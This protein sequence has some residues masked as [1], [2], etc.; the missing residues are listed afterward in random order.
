MTQQLKVLLDLPEILS[1]GASTYSKQFT[2]DCNSSPRRLYSIFWPPQVAHARAPSHKWCVHTHKFFSFNVSQNS[3]EL[4]QVSKM[5]KMYK[6]QTQAAT[7]NWVFPFLACLCTGTFKYM[8]KEL[9][10]LRNETKAN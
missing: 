3:I 7:G 2:T 9:I 8:K 1:W 10:C 5:R 6:H 4:F